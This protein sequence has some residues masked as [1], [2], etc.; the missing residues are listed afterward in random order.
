MALNQHTTMIDTF[1]Y[2]S[3]L[4]AY[5]AQALDTQIVCAPQAKQGLL[6]AERHTARYWAKP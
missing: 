6:F 1:P 4:T 5:E 2:S 3:G